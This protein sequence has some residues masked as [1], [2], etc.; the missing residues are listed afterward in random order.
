M[1]REKSTLDSTDDGETDRISQI[2]SG[3]N[4]L[5]LTQKGNLVFSFS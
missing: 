2:S 5:F 1:R 4:D 3:V